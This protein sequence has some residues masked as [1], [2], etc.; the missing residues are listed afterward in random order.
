ML[1]SL[2]SA[3]LPFSL[4]ASFPVQ[5]SNNFLPA[6]Y[7]KAVTPQDEQ[8]ILIATNNQWIRLI[9]GKDGWLLDTPKEKPTEEVLACILLPDDTVLIAMKTALNFY[10]SNLELQTAVNLNDVISGLIIEG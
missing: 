3:K 4:L 5:K 2:L 6:T 10:S 9:E 1:L 7:S 8:T